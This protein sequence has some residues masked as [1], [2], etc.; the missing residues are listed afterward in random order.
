[1]DQDLLTMIFGEP[2]LTPA[3]RERQQRLAQAAMMRS[4]SAPQPAQPM[5]AQPQIDLTGQFG[6]LMPQPGWMPSPKAPGAAR[7]LP[8]ATGG[9]TPTQPPGAAPAASQAAPVG[10]VLDQQYADL[11]RQLAE[12]EAARAAA[13]Q[14]VDRASMEK[15]YQAQQQAG[16]QHLLMALAA[17]EAGKDFAPFQGHYLKKA[18]EA[19]APMKMAGGTMTESGFIEDPVYAQNLAIQRADAKLKQI[20]SLMQGNLTQQSKIELARQAEQARREMQQLTLGMQAAIAGQSSADRRYAADLAHQDRQT[21][22]G[23]KHLPAAQTNAYVG[24]QTTISNIDSVLAAL[25][26]NPDAVGLKGYLPNVALGRMGTEGERA[27]RAD[28]A[29]IG[30][31]KIHDRSGANVTVSESPRL[32]PFIPQATDDPQTARIKLER[33]RAEAV[34]A[35]QTLEGFAAENN[36]LVPGNTSG[37]TPKAPP[38]VGEVRGGYKF[39]GGDPANPASWSK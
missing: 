29:N 38:Q 2:N 1:M 17:Q 24:N 31:L 23:N 4:P 25:E 28:I 19:Q 37:A 34:R 15:A 16:G 26:A 21:A 36:Y 32:M 35:N 8:K 10:G 7:A 5:P 18:T 11:Q 39:M 30:S 27:T 14:P 3:E 33:L 9:P 20:E 13:Y 6:Q 12:G 22:A